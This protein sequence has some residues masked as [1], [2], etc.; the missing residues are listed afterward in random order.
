MRAGLVGDP[1]DYRWSGYAEAVG[2]S[3]K[4]REGLGLVMLSRGRSPNWEKAAGPYRQL[5]YLRGQ[6]KGV[7][8]TGAPLKAGFSP[9]EVRKVLDADGELPLNVVLRCRVRYFTEGLALGSRA[10]IEDVLQQHPCMIGQR[11]PGEPCKMT[12][13]DWGDLSPAAVSVRSPQLRVGSAV[14]R[15]AGYR[16]TVS[17][18]ATV[19]ATG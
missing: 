18:A 1:A 7:S 2:G 11:H 3:G 17:S 5:L 19:K 8:E 10:Y 14:C 15:R 16:I 6:A 13:C 9:E 12:G 4:A